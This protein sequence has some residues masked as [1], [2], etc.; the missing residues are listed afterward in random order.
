[1]T[2]DELARVCRYMNI[3]YFDCYTYKQLGFFDCH[4]VHYK[5]M[6]LK[7]F[8]VL[9]VY[10]MSETRIDVFVKEVEH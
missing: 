9:E 1:M 5:N 3:A 2:L 8:L 7:K 10:V 4:D 6:G